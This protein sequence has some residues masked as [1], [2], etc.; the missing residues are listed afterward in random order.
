[1]S[2]TS[3]DGARHRAAHETAAAPVTKRTLFYDRAPLRYKVEAAAAAYVID[4]HHGHSGH[5]RALIGGILG[6]A[7]RPRVSAS[8][9]HCCARANSLACTFAVSGPRAPLVAR[10]L[11]ASAAARIEFRRR[12]HE[13]SRRSIDPFRAALLRGSLSGS[14]GRSL[15]SLAFTWRRPASSCEPA[16]SLAGRRGTGVWAAGTVDRTTGGRPE[17][18]ALVTGRPADI[19]IGL[20]GKPPPQRTLATDA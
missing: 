10:T 8:G 14:H 3:I 7:K 4:D 13:I 17:R 16:A 15:R 18:G 1:M 12:R 11:A 19:S 5:G 6:G 20:S 9:R 2:G